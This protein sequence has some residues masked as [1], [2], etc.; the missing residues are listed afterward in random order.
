MRRF[1]LSDPNLAYDSEDPAG[2]KAGMLRMGPDLGANETGAS[3]YHLPPGEALCP[4]HY[5]FGEEEW[6]LVIE[7]RPH[8]RT[9]EGTEQLDPLDVVF[10]PK[11]PDGAHKVWNEADEPAPA[12]VLM[13][14]SLVWPTATA[15]PDSDKV[16]VWASPDDKLMVKRSSNVDYYDGEKP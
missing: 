11:G 14:S 7:G 13:W 8:L 15:Y 16:G 6:L 3:L 9:P 4:Y 10:F 5:E 12:R 2:F 1:N